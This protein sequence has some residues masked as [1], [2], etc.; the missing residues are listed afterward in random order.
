M[1]CIFHIPQILLLLVLTHK[2][3]H[4]RHLGKFVV[5]VVSKKRE[6]RSE[7]AGVLVAA[8]LCIAF[9]ISGL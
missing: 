5:V 6:S 4:I 7:R 8:R 1:M 9:L 2:I 3:H